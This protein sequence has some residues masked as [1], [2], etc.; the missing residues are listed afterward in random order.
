MIKGVGIHIKVKNFKKSL[1]FYEALGFK[2]VFEYGP[3]KAVKESYF[4]TTF[5]VAGTKLEIAAG[6]RAVKPEVFSSRMANS[7]VSLMIPVDSLK[8]IIEVCKKN[9]FFISVPVRH[10]YWGTLEMVIK[11]PDGVVL[12][13]IEPYTE[14][15]AKVLNADETLGV[16]LSQGFR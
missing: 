7:K 16:F 2:K 6:H 5:E 10:Y 12:V 1:A 14:K 3:D 4:G 13:F 11:D 9:N 15:M 8:K